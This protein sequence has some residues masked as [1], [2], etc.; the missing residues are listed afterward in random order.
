V[1]PDAAAGVTGVGTVVVP[2][3]RRLPARKLWI[4]FA[5]GSSG[6]VVV[7]EGAR[8]ALLARGVS[9]LPAGVVAAYGTFDCDDAVEVAGPD[10]RV[11]AKGLTRH[12][13]ARVRELAGRRTSDLPTDVVHEVIH[14]DDLVLLP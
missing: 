1:L 4:A 10:G 6:T 12:P 3:E 13:A 11:F 9:L 2:R 7:D 5:V 8:E 14:R